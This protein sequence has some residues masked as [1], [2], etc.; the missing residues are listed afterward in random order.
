MVA[1]T[2]AL[3]RLGVLTTRGHALETLARTTHFIFDKTGT[4]TFGRPQVM[5]VEPVGSVDAQRSLALAA[6]LERGSEHPVGRA[7]AEAA[8]ENILLATD[9]RNTPGSGVEGWIDGR[10]YRVGR[11]TFV[12]ALNGNSAEDRNDLDAASTWVA[13][14]DETGLLAWFQLSDALRPGAAAAVA[15]LQAR[16]L[17]VEL[18]SGD[19]P[20]AAAHIA[21]EL[22]IATAARRDVAAGQIES[23]AGVATARRSGGDGRRWR[24][25]RAG[26]GGSPGF[27]GDGQRRSI[28]AC[29]RGHD[30]AVRTA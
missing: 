6:A 29:H 19:R 5:A 14:G 2:G 7:L 9:L 22:G 17:A 20:D 30:F 3:T 1:A 18:L 28:G 27:A 23:A 21:R 10:R 8:G 24:Q 4:L 11:P 13:L 25:R 16:G 15:A 12:A 26:A